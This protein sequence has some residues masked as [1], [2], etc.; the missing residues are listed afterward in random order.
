MKNSTGILACSLAALVGCEQNLS[1]PG[2]P[3]DQV[4]VAARFQAGTS[5]PSVEWLEAKLV[6]PGRDSQ[7]L[8]ASYAAVKG[9]YLSFQPIVAS[10]S[11][12]LSLTGYDSIAGNR[13]V[14]WWTTQGGTARQSPAQTVLLGAIDSLAAPRGTLAP[15]SLSVGATF[16]LAGTW[17][18]TTDGTDPRTSVSSKSVSGS[19]AVAA[20]GTVCLARRESS[21]NGPTIW[22][23]ST[24]WS[25]KELDTSYMADKAGGIYPIVRIGAQKWMASNLNWNSPNSSCHNDSL[26]NC[27]KYGRLYDWAEASNA[28][29]SGWHLPTREDWL[30]L[31][32][33]VDAGNGSSALRSDSGWA[34]TYTGS[35]SSGFGAV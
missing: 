6:R 1:A 19:L 15:T 31:V 3:D 5:V 13:I 25:F 35:N 27:A 17:S 26:I 14:R 23:D 10:D 24:C 28:C 11:F 32:V 18:Y 7:I 22:S 30:N 4:V 33:F 29:P 8:T 12:Q 2:A 21:P 20:V 34:P 9:T 16:A